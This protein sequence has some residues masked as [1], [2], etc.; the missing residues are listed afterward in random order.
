VASEQGNSQN[1]IHVVIVLVSRKI[2]KNGD[3]KDRPLCIKGSKM[4]TLAFCMLGNDK[5]L[6]F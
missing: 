5:T 1:F 6:N 4:Y 3:L 2:N